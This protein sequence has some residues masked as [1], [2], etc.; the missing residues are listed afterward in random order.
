MKVEKAQKGA[1]S[2]RWG[3]RESAIFD[4]AWQLVS[5]R[6]FDQTT[7]ADVAREVGLSEGS[8]YNYFPSKKML[9][10][11]LAERW[12]TGQA[13]KLSESLAAIATRKEKLGLIIHFHLAD[14]L[15]EPEL[16]LMW[17][18]ELRATEAYSDSTT[19]DIF[20]Q[21]TN[22]LK[23][24]LLDAREAGEL[25]SEL[26]D[27]H[28]RDVIYGGVEHIAWTTIVQQRIDKFDIA[29]TAR[30]LTDNYW[31]MMGVDPS[32]ARPSQTAEA[33]SDMATQLQRI[34]EKLD[35]LTVTE[36]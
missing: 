29:A 32:H 10:I 31:T 18:R 2:G 11:R 21:Y 35:R 30:L 3:D 14:I 33:G 4:A 16:Y 7:M 6:G 34:E 26:S 19:R 36:G 15:Q 24:L 8:L 28:L 12:F 22:L 9:G 27:E 25:K 1:R 23:S 17:I 13:D 20:R 5:T